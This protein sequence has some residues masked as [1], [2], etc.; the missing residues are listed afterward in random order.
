MRTDQVTKT[1]IF[2]LFLIIQTKGVVMNPTLSMEGHLNS[3]LHSLFN[4]NIFYRRT[5][6]GT[7]GRSSGAHIWKISGRGVVWGSSKPQV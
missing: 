1:L 2:N 6:P 3:R 5:G 4:I 7:N